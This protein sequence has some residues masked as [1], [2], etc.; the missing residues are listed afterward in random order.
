MSYTLRYF[1]IKARAETCRALLSYSGAPWKNENPEWPAE[2]P[3]QPFG[4]LPVLIETRKDDSEFVLTDSIAIER[5][6]VAKYNLSAGGDAETIARQDEL[7]N[8]IKDIY[9]LVVLYKFGHEAARPSVM[10]K[11]TVLSKAMVNLHEDFLKKNGSNGHYFGNKT[12]Y[13]DIALYANLVA[14][15]EVG[16]ELMA[17]AAEPFSEENAPLINK[18]LKTVGADPAMASYVATQL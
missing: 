16:T 15:R 6:I 1:P 7:R 14:L 18:V 3:N 17:G 13:V 4:K 9:E 2:K 5:Y 8:Q 12:T 11:F 10:E